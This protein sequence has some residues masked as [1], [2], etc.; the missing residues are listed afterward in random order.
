MIFLAIVLGVWGALIEY[1]TARLHCAVCHR[2]Y[3][4]FATIDSHG[5]ETPTCWR[6]YREWRRAEKTRR[7][8]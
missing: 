3:A 1:L 6:H 7:S 4:I 8:R 2:G 5:H